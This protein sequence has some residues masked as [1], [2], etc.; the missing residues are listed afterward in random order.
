MFASGGNPGDCSLTTS[1]L[2]NS[3]ID[4]I[5][6]ANQLTPTLDNSSAVEILTWN[7][8]WTTYDDET[9]LRLKTDFARSECLGGVMVWAVS[10]DN[11]NGSYS[12][13][14]AGVAKRPFTSYQLSTNSNGS[15]YL[16]VAT[17]NTQCMWTGCGETCP[18]DYVTVSRG[19]SGAR[20]GEL[21]LDGTA[22]PTGT[23]HTLCCPSSTT[24]PQCG[25]YTHNNGNCNSACPINTHEVGS[26]S[27]YC[28]NNDYQAA[29]CETGL[30]STQLYSTLEWSQAPLCDSGTCPWA[31]SSDSTTLTSSASGSGGAKCNMRSAGW[32]AQNW[33]IQERKLCA[34]TSNSDK[35]WD[36]C[37]WY[38]NLGPTSSGRSSECAS[39]CPTGKVRV[40][41]DQYGGG[42]LKNG[43]ARSYCCDANYITYS[44][45]DSP[46][47]TEFETDLD[48]FL[49]D[50][51]C[52][53]S[54]SLSAK[55]SHEEESDI[56][57]RAST[58]KTS[59]IDMAYFLGQALVTLLQDKV[60]T[61]LESAEE[62]YWN[63]KVPQNFSN[64]DMDTIQKFANNSTYFYYNGPTSAAND[65]VCR[66]PVYNDLVLGI[67]PPACVG[68]V[69]AAD[70]EPDLCEEEDDEDDDVSLSSRMLGRD[71]ADGKLH[72]LEKRAKAKS[73]SVWCAST[74]T[75]TTG[76]K[77]Q[78]Q[79]YPSA[80]K[81]TSSDPQY[82]SARN[83]VN[84]VD[85]GNPQ[86][87]PQIKTSN[88]YDSEFT[89]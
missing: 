38:D 89:Y 20:K 16:E 68:D 25:W 19:D 48:G 82:N 30:S 13:A 21:M 44:K 34:D 56:I 17:Q 51:Y 33:V 23:T 1:M 4:S 11:S 32:I 61:Q 55:R 47:L 83:L 70:V 49:P 2:M 84:E 81:W 42:C 28:K 87:S 22:C 18:S 31:D 63:S 78:P 71:E 66:L 62:D 9:T 50:P 60:Y 6:A 59:P 8:Q 26:N 58:L 69:C 40:A 53:T 37:D 52:G 88:I 14:L 46:T 76:L 79:P 36:G 74:N 65:L 80:G 27:Q 10:H 12:E 67:I 29:C 7:D 35:T 3:E 73:Y 57:P 77:Y 85:C 24:V 64:L 75:L 43:G 72:W 5:R 15:A 54:S 45:E 39:S 41:M 86:I